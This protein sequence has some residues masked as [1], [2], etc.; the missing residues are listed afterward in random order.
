ME[1]KIIVK[2]SPLRGENNSKNNSKI[3]PILVP[4]FGP[5]PSWPR[6]DFAFRRDLDDEPHTEM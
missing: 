6:L 4:S 1:R 2:K 3:S 5:V